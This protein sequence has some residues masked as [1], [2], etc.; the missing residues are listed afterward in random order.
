M[1]NSA[2]PKPRAP[3]RRSC[4]VLNRYWL[5]CVQFWLLIRAVPG[6]R[7]A[8]DSL[9]ISL[10]PSDLACRANTGLIALDTSVADI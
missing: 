8:E 5:L 9:A 2:H 10:S 6:S 1:L 7:R 4:T 3:D